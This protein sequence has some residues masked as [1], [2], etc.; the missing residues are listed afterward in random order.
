[1]KRREFITLLGGAAVAWPLAARAQQPKMP[2]IGFLN[3]GSPNTFAHL[4]DAF[5]QGLKEAGYIEGQNVTIEYRWAESRYD[6]L[7]A[8]AAELVNRQVAVIIATGGEPSA[9]AAKA[10]TTKI[11][12][13]FTAG[14]DPVKQGLVA[15]LKSMAC[16]LMRVTVCSWHSTAA[17]AV[18]KCPLLK[19]DRPCRRAAVTSQFGPNSDISQRRK[20]PKSRNAAIS[21]RT[22][23]C[24]RL[25]RKHRQRPM[26]IQ[27]DS[28][29]AQGLAGCSAAG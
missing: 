6:Q 13:V 15:S 3:S 29:L 27:N 7:P 8:L 22:V 4:A 10:A 19:V 5:R 16:K 14:G 11:P 20:G 28:G 12:I 1:M 18:T 9:V 2:V 17:P 24:Y 21:R 23:V 25:G 26:R